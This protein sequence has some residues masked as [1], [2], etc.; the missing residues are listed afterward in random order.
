MAGFSFG[1]FVTSHAVQAL[2]AVR[3]LDRV[4]LVGTAAGRFDVAELPKD[5]HA[6][7]LVL[8]G[9]EDDT[10]PLAAALDWAERAW[11]EAVAVEPHGV[12]GRPVPEDVG[13]GMGNAADL[14]VLPAARGANVQ[15]AQQV[16]P[17]RVK[18]LGE[19][20]AGHHRG[21]GLLRFL[22]IRLVSGQPCGRWN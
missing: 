18:I 4:V 16:A 13:Q 7:T 17:H 8:H 22:L 19:R 21:R 1:A 14:I 12:S 15:L 20:R 11:K 10:V 2:H 3:T 5:L 9:E 6:K